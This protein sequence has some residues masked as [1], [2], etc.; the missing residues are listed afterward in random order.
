MARGFLYAV[1]AAATVGIVACS[2]PQPERTT[3][4]QFVP[5][6]STDPCDFSNSLINDYFPAG[7]QADVR[8]LKQSMANA[9]HG[10][11]AARTFGF[12]IMDS[13]G[14]FSRNFTLDPSK[15]ATLTVA[16][17]G[18]MF[19]NSAD[20]T[21]PTNSIA[22]FTAAL[23][24]AAGGAYF[25]RGRLLTG[26]SDA[27]ADDA[28]RSQPVLGAIPVDPPAPKTDGN[29]SGIAPFSGSWTNMLPPITTNERRAL[30]YG[31][32][33]TA[34]P[35]VYEWATVPS[36]LTF[37]PQAVLA[38]CVTD[39]GATAMIH[40]EAVGVLE[41][42]NSGIC[43]T[44]QSLT[45]IEGWGPK[46]LAGRIGRMM[47]AF[48]PTP[49]QAAVVLASTG[50][51]TSNLP[52]SKV[53]KLTITANSLTALWKDQPPALIKGTDPTKNPMSFTV[54]A[55]VG[56]DDEPVFGACAYLVGR[57]NNGFPTKLVGPQNVNCVN[58]PGGDLDA[59]SVLLQSHTASASLADFGMV[60][61]TKFGGIV[62]TGFVDI[63]LRDGSGAPPPIKSNVKPTK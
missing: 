11:V 62:F 13:I 52:K 55:K 4:P 47:R 23:N 45:T 2:D 5:T 9:G 16:L 10:T 43:N 7:R 28:K 22:D 58:P 14:W 34:N 18:C 35:L 50:G 26:S 37:S 6:G 42:V 3:G 8:T 54:S 44:P 63:L 21:Y 38:V 41:Y 25:V 53:K 48:S 15:G 19:D 59:L 57:N 20:F 33:V 49:L 40:E 12:E 17:I 29:L 51:K 32:R 46:A 61:V 39:P 56:T 60:G 36:E 1:A 31:Y 27:G 30:F 24:S